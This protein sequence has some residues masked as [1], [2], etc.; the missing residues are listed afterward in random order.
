MGSVFLHLDCRRIV[1]RVVLYI[2][3]TSHFQV[4]DKL[5]RSTRYQ[6]YLLLYLGV[7][8]TDRSV[9]RKTISIRAWIMGFLSGR[10]RADERCSLSD[11]TPYFGID[12]TISQR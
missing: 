3:G 5:G 7:P 10:P 1:F 9:A 2:M 4:A 6:S 11:S 12:L 8:R